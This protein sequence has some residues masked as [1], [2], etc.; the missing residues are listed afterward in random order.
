[1]TGNEAVSGKMF[2]CP[3]LW[4]TASLMS[5]F[6]MIPFHLF[7]TLQVLCVFFYV[8]SCSEL[9]FYCV[10]LTVLMLAITDLPCFYGN[11]ADKVY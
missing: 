4:K 9:A 7:V 11:R 5:A 3:A 10:L 2:L 8:E 1:M 6:E